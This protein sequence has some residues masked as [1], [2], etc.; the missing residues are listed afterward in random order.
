MLNELAEDLAAFDAV[1]QMMFRKTQKDFQG[2]ETGER[3]A[4]LSCDMLTETFKKCKE[5]AEFIKRNTDFLRLSIYMM[6]IDGYRI[7]AMWADVYAIVPEAAEGILEGYV[8]QEGLP[9]LIY[10][11]LEL[12][13]EA[14]FGELSE[15][16]EV[17]EL[18]G[19]KELRESGGFR[20]VGEITKLDRLRAALA[21]KVQKY[22]YQA[23]NSHLAAIWNE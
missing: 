12:I 5:D 9:Q 14:I 6:E 16:G 11:N 20:R 15:N 19:S 8:M 7:G 22:D 1:T 21:E 17:E 2:R 4:V 23:I 13:F 10:H 3:A 18:E